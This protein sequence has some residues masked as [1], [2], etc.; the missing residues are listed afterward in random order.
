MAVVSVVGILLPMIGI[1]ILPEKLEEFGQ[2]LAE[3]VAFCLLVY[4]MIRQKKKEDLT[5]VG[6]IKMGGKRARS[7]RV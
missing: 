3:V 6:G 2:A 1:N 4:T 7:E 5:I